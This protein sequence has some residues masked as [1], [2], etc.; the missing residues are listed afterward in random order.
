M[1]QRDLNR[2]GT[3]L[4]RRLDER[5]R[6]LERKRVTIIDD[7]LAN[8]GGGAKGDKGDPGDPGAAAVVSAYNEGVL[9]GVYDL[10][11]FVGDAITASLVGTTLTVTVEGGGCP[12][13]PVVMAANEVFETPA[14]SQMIALMAP[15]SAPGS[16]IQPGAGA[17]FGV[18]GG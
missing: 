1:S 14:N 13:I 3:T 7:L 8:A 6:T 9:L 2:D 10:I 5:V 4:L 16:I 12:C 11:N 17:I 18:H 15:K